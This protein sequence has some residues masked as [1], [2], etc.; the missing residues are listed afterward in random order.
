VTWSN[1][2]KSLRPAQKSVLLVG[3]GVVFCDREDER[4][5]FQ[6]ETT[7]CCNR[8]HFNCPGD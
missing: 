7:M 5:Y 4:L 1:F 6:E 3:G 8:T 2:V